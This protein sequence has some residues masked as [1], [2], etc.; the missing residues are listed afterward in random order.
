MNSAE[1]VEP[2]I[3][4][5]EPLADAPDGAAQRYQLRSASQLSS[6]RQQ[7]LET[8]HRNFLKVASSNLGDLLRLDFTLGLASVQI[9][10]YGEMVEERG[11]ENQCVLFRMHPQPGIWLLDLPSALSVGLVDRMMGGAGAVPEGEHPEMTELDQAIFQQ[12]AETLLADYAKSWRPHAE[13][14]A[15]VLRQVRN[16]NYQLIHQPDALI[17]RVAIEVAFKENKSTLWLVVPITSVEDLLVRSLATD[18]GVKAEAA[19]KAKD[20]KSP[21][22]SVPV[23]VSVRWQGFQMTLRDVEAIGVGD[24]L[25]LDNKKCETAAVWLGDKAKFSGRVQREPHRTVITLTGNL[26]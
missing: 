10:T 18:E 23:P 6:A 20:S 15:E 22:G 4:N 9:Q 16:L 21:V 12:F 3:E 19:T 14:K 25:V 2:E 24:V 17:L 11:T 5:P 13:L 1:I 8:W 7:G 26:E